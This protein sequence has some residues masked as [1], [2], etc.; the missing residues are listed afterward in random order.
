MTLETDDISP[1]SIL[2]QWKL[3]KKSVETTPTQLINFSRVKKDD[4]PFVPSLT[5]S[6][7][8]N[9]SS[10]NPMAGEI[11]L[12]IEGLKDLYTINPEAV[13]SL[14]L[15]KQTFSQKVKLN[16]AKQI[17]LQKHLPLVSLFDPTAINISHENLKTLC[18]EKYELYQKAYSIESYKN[19]L[20]VTEKQ[21]LNHLWM[22]HRA[23]QITASKC[24]NVCHIDTEK[25]SSPS[26]LA[27]IIQYSGTKSNKYTRYGNDKEPV[28]RK[29]F[30]ETQ[31][32]H[33]DNFVVNET[34]F[35]VHTEYPC[36]GASLDGIVTYS[37]HETKGLE[38]KCPYNY[39]KD[40]VN[41][42]KD[43]RFSIHRS[44]SI[45]KNHPYYYQIQLQM[46]VCKLSKIDFF[47]FPP[48][49]GG[50]SSLYVR[51][52]IDNQFLQYKIFPKLLRY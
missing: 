33:H 47:I 40:L 21:A 43:R 46:S 18:N 22:L 27:T 28:A 3:T 23:G 45:K 48:A 19:L 52:P 39:Q 8:K 13:F 32:G 2:C 14:Q 15:T 38:I 5:C 7:V 11:P 4:L 1:T 17:L 34:G 44:N 10:N 41:W 37:C 31:N 26:L 6:Y 25:I 50:S 24:Y 35:K 20:L 51:V 9:F 49:N 16:L 42:G 36:I 30:A 12:T 29:Y